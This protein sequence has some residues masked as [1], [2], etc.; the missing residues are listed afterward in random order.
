MR[1]KLL[2]HSKRLTVIAFV[3]YGCIALLS[4][5]AICILGLDAEQITAIVSIY[6]GA[7]TLCG[8]VITGYMGNS[9]IEKYSAYKYRLEEANRNTIENG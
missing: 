9:G 3:A 5:A 2:Q 6:N 8:V 7:M 4:M 1:T